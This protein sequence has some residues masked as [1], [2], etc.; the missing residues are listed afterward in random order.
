MI[1]HHGRAAT[2]GH[3][4]VSLRQQNNKW[5]NVD[6]TDIF[7]VSASD[8]AVDRVQEVL[9]LSLPSANDGVPDRSP[10]LLFYTRVD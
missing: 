9:R 10:Y 4:T 2:G 3:Y 8:V 7:Q 6:D 5:I 1:Y